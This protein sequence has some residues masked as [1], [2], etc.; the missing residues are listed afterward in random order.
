MSR[1]RVPRSSRSNPRVGRRGDLP[2]DGAGC[3]SPSLPSQIHHRPAGCSK[4]RADPLPSPS[5]H[6]TPWTAQ[7]LCIVRCEE[8]LSDRSR[9]PETWSWRR[10]RPRESAMVLVLLGCSPASSRP[11]CSPASR[12]CPRNRVLSLW[13][14]FLGD[15]CRLGQVEE[16]GC[17]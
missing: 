4:G 5:C 12:Y 1:T 15:D 11:D 6:T 9:C 16:G 7:L 2:L 14:V 8:T 17:C 10:E 13:L 3:P